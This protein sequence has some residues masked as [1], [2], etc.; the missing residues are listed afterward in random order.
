MSIY[1]RLRS[2]L[3]SLNYYQPATET[4]I[5]RV[6]NALN[7]KLPDWLRDLYLHSN[8]ITASDSSSDYLLALERNH[9]FP[10]SLLSWNLFLRDEWLSYLPEF[11]EHCP[12]LRNPGTDMFAR[13]GSRP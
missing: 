9:N 4:Q 6:E 11:K 5:D 1:E 3:P 8:G 10:E 2:E 13:E 7:V 12:E